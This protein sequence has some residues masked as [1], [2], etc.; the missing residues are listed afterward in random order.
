MV[1]PYAVKPLT[2]QDDATEQTDPRQVSTPLD[3]DGFE[4]LLRKLGIDRKWRHIIEGLHN[5]FNVGINIQLNRSF[6][7]ENHKS[8]NLV[9]TSSL[10]CCCE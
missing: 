3:A 6:V 4:V 8:A 9:R 1:A 10:L 5:G 7:F 2:E